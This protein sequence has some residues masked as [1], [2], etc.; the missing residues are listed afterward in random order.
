MRKVCPKVRVQRINSKLKHIHISTNSF[1]SF[2]V[3]SHFKNHKIKIGQ[4]GKAI[5]TYTYI[6]ISIPTTDNRLRIAVKANI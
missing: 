4:E 3:N 2:P 6:C 1:P 5:E